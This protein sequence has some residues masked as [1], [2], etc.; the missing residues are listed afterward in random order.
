MESFKSYKSSNGNA[1]LGHDY[2]ENKSLFVCVL[3]V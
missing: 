1:K 3:C 2:N